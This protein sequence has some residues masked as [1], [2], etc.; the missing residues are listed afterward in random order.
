MTNKSPHPTLQSA[1]DFAEVD[2]QANRLGQLTVRQ[3][4]R[5]FV[6]A[7]VI[8][9][10]LLLIT[11]F[12]GVISAIVIIAVLVGAEVSAGGLILALGGEVVTVASG[13]LVWSLHRRYQNYL[14][15]GHVQSI[16]GPVTCY[17]LKVR[18]ANEASRIM[19]YVRIDNLEFEVPAAALVAFTNHEH[20][21]LY[22]VPQPRTLLSAEKSTLPALA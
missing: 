12:I 14:K 7:R 3:R 16:S 9:I 17:E 2:L 21:R 19:F 1:L 15:P 6:R 13:Y 22:Y 11:V 8:Y 4:N 5:V 18:L 20:Y 10:S